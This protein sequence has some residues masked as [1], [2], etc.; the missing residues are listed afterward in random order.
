MTIPVVWLTGKV[1]TPLFQ[2]VFVGA[3]K[4]FLSAPRGCIPDHERRA[5]HAPD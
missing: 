4:W 3:G 5:H 2:D 1:G